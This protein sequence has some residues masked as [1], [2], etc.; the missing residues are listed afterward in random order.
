MQISCSAGVL[1]ATHVQ[2]ARNTRKVKRGPG[3]GCGRPAGCD[4]RRLTPCPMGV[5]TWV[6]RQQDG[7]HTG[8]KQKSKLDEQH[9]VAVLAQVHLVPIISSVHLLHRGH[10]CIVADNVTKK[11]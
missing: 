9:P 4:T 11:D 7:A 2:R 10:D 5:T 1:P 6:T 3:T 8:G